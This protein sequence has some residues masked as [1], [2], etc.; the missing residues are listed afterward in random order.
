MRAG[1]V[2]DLA[3]KLQRQQ[4]VPHQTRIYPENPW[5]LQQVLESYLLYAFTVLI[6]TGGIMLLSG[7]SVAVCVCDSVFLSV[8]DFLNLDLF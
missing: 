7:C 1:D 5:R 3:L 4:V 6:G 8:C 2:Q